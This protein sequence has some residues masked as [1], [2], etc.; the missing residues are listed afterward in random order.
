MQTMQIYYGSSF[1]SDF[2]RFGKYYRVMAQ[3]DPS[4]RTDANSLDGIYIKNGSGEMVPAK[5]LVR[6]KRV[7]GPETVTRNN[8]FNA[9]TINGVP[10]PGYSTGDAIK[11]I[12]E[13]AKQVLPRGYAYEWTGVTREEIKTGG[14]TG[15][16]FLLSIIFVFF[17]LAA[18]YESYILPFAIILTIPTGV[19]GV[20]SFIGWGGIESN[21]YVQI[22]LIM[23][24]GLLA[25]NAILIVEYAVQR[26]RAGM[27]L[28]ESALE[29]SRLRLRPILMTSFAF[30]VG[31][32]PLIW[33]HG[34]SAKG[35]ASI[36]TSAV[37]GMLTGVI[38]GIF[39]IP[40]LY[41][42]FQYLQEKVTG[43]TGPREISL[44]E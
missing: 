35:N 2:N 28:I 15:F 24:I 7:Y 32:L 31:L 26:R 1:V 34:A 19:L 9:V 36:G 3:A 38:L 42:I 33:T 40:V 8:L 18:Q 37:G 11:A 6:L 21:I 25:K 20:Y 29:G 44:S 12:E 10:K 14:Q 22:G 39:I 17:L 16:I 41:V 43:R 23:L 5:S 4:Y 30:I 27:G 13:T